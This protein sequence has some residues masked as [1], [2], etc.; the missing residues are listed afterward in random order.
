M[1]I[2]RWSGRWGRP[3][4]WTVTAWKGEFT[5]CS[6]GKAVRV[7]S[8][9]NHRRAGQPLVQISV[10]LFGPTSQSRLGYT[11]YLCC[12]NDHSR[13]TAVYPLKS[14][15]KALAAF[16][17]Y[18][19]LVEIQTG[20]TIK[21]LRSDQGGES[22]STEVRRWCEDRGIDHADYAERRAQAR[23]E[24]THFTTMNDVRTLLCLIHSG[25]MR[26]NTLYTPGTDS[27]IA[28]ERYRSISSNLTTRNVGPT[29]PILAPSA[30]PAS[31]ESYTLRPNY[32]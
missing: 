17:V 4:S 19:N 30:R 22:M 32:T 24:R 6:Q 23:V 5:P 27:Q 7:A 28:R 8:T 29:I 21:T 14:K 11:Y 18:A 13:Y 20:R 10:D 31:T 25:S 1:R 26:C 12:H 9:A 3:E 16:K 15:S 2:R